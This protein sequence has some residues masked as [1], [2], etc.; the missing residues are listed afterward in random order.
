MPFTYG[1]L[2]DSAYA[3]LTRCKYCVPPLRKAEIDAINAQHA[4]GGDH[5]PIMTAARAKAAKTLGLDTAE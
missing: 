3:K 4:P 2:E 1:E 5:D